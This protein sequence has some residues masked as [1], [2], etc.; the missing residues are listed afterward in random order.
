[1]TSLNK[2]GI[3]IAIPKKYE[4]ICLK[5]IIHLR[6]LGCSLPIE[7]WEI[8][9]EIST[10]CRE[11]LNRIKDIYFK[12]V[13]D[14]YQDGNFWKGFQIKGFILNHTSFEE[15]ILCDADIIFHQNPEILFESV[16]YITTGTYFF[17]DLEK[18][19]FS[20]LN[21]K[22][23]QF[24]QKFFYSKFNNLNFFLKRKEWIKSLLPKQSL[25]FPA[26][27]SY[28]YTDE[29]PKMPVKEAL[30]ES[31]VVAFNKIKKE[32][33]L[34]NIYR[35]NKDYK[36]TYQYIWG[37]KETFW[38]GCVMANESYYFN[39]TSGYMGETTKH[40]THDYLEQKFFSQKG[41]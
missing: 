14:F 24:K 21:S 19:Q 9:E 4:E 18:W 5:N 1:M 2:K 17:K 30:Q 16:G 22:L 11:K 26:E 10:S 8:G 31:G 20:K 32:K 33:S 27:W 15:V 34:D 6:S 35:L 3:I 38:L 41:E 13:N 29:I 7:L 40:L 36:N 25:L 12:N 39:Q 28:I 37:D 23:E